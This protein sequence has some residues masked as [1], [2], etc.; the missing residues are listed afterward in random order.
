[1]TQI[2]SAKSGNKKQLYKNHFL[3]NDTIGNRNVF[4]KSH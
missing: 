1:M 4:F 3:N 2:N